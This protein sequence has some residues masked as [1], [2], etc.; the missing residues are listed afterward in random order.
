MYFYRLLNNIVKYMKRLLITFS[1]FCLLLVNV[2]ANPPEKVTWEPNIKM[3]GHLFPSYII[4]GAN[5]NFKSQGDHYIGE[6]KGLIG[7]EISSSYKNA[8]Y[9]I[10]INAR[11]IADIT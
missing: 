1:F 7:I 2:F 4:A 8:K 10:E 11:E 3:E 5:T 9:R 6:P